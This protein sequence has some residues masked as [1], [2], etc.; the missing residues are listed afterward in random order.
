MLFALALIVSITALEFDY[1]V[2]S[3]V[4]AGAAALAAFLASRSQSK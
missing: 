2:F 4:F 1:R 3:A